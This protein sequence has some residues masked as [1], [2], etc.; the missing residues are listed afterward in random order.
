VVDLRG[1]WVGS[2]PPTPWKIVEGKGEEEKE[3]EEKKRG[4]GKT[5]KKRE[6][7]KREKERTDEVEEKE[8]INLCHPLP[9]KID[10]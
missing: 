10:S 4:R 3:S 8:I 2:N 1:G 6:R 5:R 7:E 9:L